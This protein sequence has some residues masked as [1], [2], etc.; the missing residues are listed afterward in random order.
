MMNHDGLYVNHVMV[1]ILSPEPNP[2][3]H[4]YIYNT[5]DVLYRRKF[6]IYAEI[7]RA[8]TILRQTGSLINGPY[9]NHFINTTSNKKLSLLK[10]LEHII[11]VIDFNNHMFPGYFESC[12]ENFYTNVPS[13]WS[14]E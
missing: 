7:N 11:T 13:D 8:D 5:L 10:E 4:K 1:T 3:V 12:P 9:S 6:A 14:Y 2:N